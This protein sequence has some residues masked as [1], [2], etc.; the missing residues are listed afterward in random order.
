VPIDPNKFSCVR[1][2][3]SQ[4]EL[5]IM[6]FLQRTLLLGVIMIKPPPHR[7]LLHFPSSLHIEN[8][9]IDSVLLP[10]KGTIHKL[11]FNPSACATQN[12]NIVEDLAQAPCA[13]LT[14]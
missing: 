4:L 9:I 13:M 1:L 12:Y 5:R 2:L 8:P 14:L 10:L 11:D 6:M 3:T 7:F